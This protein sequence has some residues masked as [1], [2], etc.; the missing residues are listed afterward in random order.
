MAQMDLLDAVAATMFRPPGDTEPARLFKETL[1]LL[2]VA[3][4]IDV[5]EASRA[6]LVSDARARAAKALADAARL[7][8]TAIPLGD[9]RYSPWL[10]EIVDPPSVLW[11]RGR[12]PPFDRLAVAPV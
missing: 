11:V 3:A 6:T 7:G 5:P 2:E 4:R 10:R 8:L 1:D 12:I 9:E